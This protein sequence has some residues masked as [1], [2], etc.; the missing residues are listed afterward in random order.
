M[1]VIHERGCPYEGLSIEMAIQLFQAGGVTLARTLSESP[2]GSRAGAT[3]P[4]P[5]DMASIASGPCSTRS[6]PVPRCTSCCEVGP[7]PNRVIHDLTEARGRSPSQQGYCSCTR[8]RVQ[9]P[10]A[11]LPGAVCTAAPE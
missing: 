2:P 8:A 4:R 11:S 9:E 6:A 1:T 3:L 10:A 5:P 7:P